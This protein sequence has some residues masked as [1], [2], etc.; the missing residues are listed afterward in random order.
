MI[1]GL[2][3]I[4]TV[5]CGLFVYD[6]S[7][8]QYQAS[9]GD[10]DREDIFNLLHVEE[11]H[12]VIA[13][14]S[15]GLFSFEADIKHTPRFFDSLDFKS[16]KDDFQGL[17]MNVGVVIQTAANVRNCEIWMCAHTERKLFILEPHTLSIQ[18]VL[19]YT[20]SDWKVQKPATR[21]TTC[22]KNQQSSPP[23]LTIIVNMQA[24]LVEYSMKVGV[25]D[26][27][28]ILLW[29]VQSKKLEKNF[30]CMEYCLANV[31]SISGS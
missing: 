3:W 20:E 8:L 23:M 11:T 4:S 19:V 12:H 13:L 5:G 21:Q 17:A 18:E 16:H 7:T 30:D 25:A 24:V 28:M 27:W 1:D 9:W 31:D 6:A 10:K 29:D 26:N 22:M 15:R 14:A 2:I